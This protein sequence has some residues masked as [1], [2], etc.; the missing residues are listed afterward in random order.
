MVSLV[1][2]MRWNKLVEPGTF[3]LEA[4]FISLSPPLTMINC[5]HPMFETLVGIHTGQ[6][7]G[8]SV[9]FCWFKGSG[10]ASRAI[11]GESLRVPIIYAREET[12]PILEKVVIIIHNEQ[13][14]QC[15]EI[16]LPLWLL[17]GKGGWKGWVSADLYFGLYADLGLFP[18]PVCIS[19]DPQNQ[20]AW[21]ALPL[22]YGQ[23]SCIT[24]IHSNFDF[25]EVVRT[26]QTRSYHLAAR[27]MFQPEVLIQQYLRQQHFQHMWRMSVIEP[28][29]PWA[30]AYP[31]GW[32]DLEFPTMFLTEEGAGYWIA[33]F[34]NIL[35]PTEMWAQ[36]FITLTFLLRWV[37]SVWAYI[38]RLY[39]IEG[40]IGIWA[41]PLDHPYKHPIP[42]QHGSTW[43]LWISRF[44]MWGGELP[45]PKRKVQ[46]SLIRYIWMEFCWNIGYILASRHPFAESAHAD[47]IRTVQED[48]ERDHLD[49]ECIL[50]AYRRCAW[51]CIQV[52]KSLF[53]MMPPSMD[54]L[55][56]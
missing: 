14:E 26:T 33:D 46:P 42:T 39:E 48:W 19:K 55:S 5:S 32:K 49:T 22:S 10:P 36:C 15:M 23:T 11:S 29:C 50:P 20:C 24:F 53:T 3:S 7:K 38:S 34:W 9:Y 44:E 30:Q 18:L 2:S 41:P 27:G 13:T 56:L 31:H 51:K 28:T 45:F 4:E 21:Y 54:I 12:L 17:W 6:W 35:I 1:K 40:M 16:M 52:S 37:R 43:I 47:F 25:F 8:E